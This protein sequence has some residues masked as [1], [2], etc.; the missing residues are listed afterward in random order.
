MPVQQKS[1][2][3]LGLPIP[4]TAG[5]YNGGVHVG[6]NVAVNLN[7]TFAWKL[8][9]AAFRL[10]I[11]PEVE[12]L[13]AGEPKDI[14]KDWVGIRKL[15]RGAHRDHDQLRLE[16]AVALLDGHGCGRRGRMMAAFE[17]HHG[18]RELIDRIRGPGGGR[19]RAAQIVNGRRNRLFSEAF[20]DNHL[21]VYISADCR[22]GHRKQ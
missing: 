16:P 21:H 12:R 6:V 3:R 15:H 2:V 8:H 18:A 20:G 5:D 14:V 10:R 1:A 22:Q 7:H 9:R 11:I 17:N 19:Y 4:R 13:R